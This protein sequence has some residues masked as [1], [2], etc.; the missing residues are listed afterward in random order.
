M[1]PDQPESQPVPSASAAQQLI[2]VAD[3]LERVM[4][5][6]PLYARMLGRF[7]RDYAEGAAP[8]LRALQQ[9]NRA[10]AHRQAHTL[11]GAA[12]MIGAHSLHDHASAAE[13]ALRTGSGN[14]HTA[15]IELDA[16][17]QQVLVALDALLADA[18]VAATPTACAL[19]PP[20]DMLARLALLLHNGDGGAVELVEECGPALATI[21]GE[22]A[23]KRLTALVNDFNF[24]AA[25]RLLKAH[26][27]QTASG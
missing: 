6:R 14:E 17:L 27:Q 25:L 15:L 18:V 20:P 19:L 13:V 8:M 3:G 22:P 16:H 7:R 10:L 23:C 9:G 26:A 5:D 11:K 2:D 21:L 24:A 12:G 1:P 4:D